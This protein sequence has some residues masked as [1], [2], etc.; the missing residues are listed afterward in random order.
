MCKIYGG[1]VIDLRQHLKKSLFL[2]DRVGINNVTRAAENFFQNSFFSD[3]DRRVIA[4]ILVK[5]VLKIGQEI[6]KILS[7]S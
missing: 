5:T 7:F 4:I 6:T 1:A 3:D 2:V